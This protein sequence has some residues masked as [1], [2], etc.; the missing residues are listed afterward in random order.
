MER[1]FDLH[2]RFAAAPFPQQSACVPFNR[3]TSEL[4]LNDE[5]GP[6][7]SQ[8]PPASNPPARN[9]DDDN[10]AEASAI[11][12]P[13]ERE[14]PVHKANTNIFN[15]SKKTRT[16]RK[17]ASFMDKAFD[18]IAT[19]FF[20]LGFVSGL[21]AGVPF[22]AVGLVASAPFIGISKLFNLY[23]NKPVNTLTLKVTPET[24]DDIIKQLKALND[25]GRPVKTLRIEFSDFLRDELNIE[26]VLSVRDAILNFGRHIQSIEL[27]NCKIEKLGYTRFE[28]PKRW[29]LPK[30]H[31]QF[32]THKL[33][34]KY[35]V[36]SVVFAN[37]NA[38]DKETLTKYSETI[39]SATKW[40]EFGC[41]HNFEDHLQ[42]DV[43][44][45]YFAAKDSVYATFVASEVTKK[46][47][48]G[49]FSAKEVNKI[50]QVIK[51][52]QAQM[53]KIVALETKKAE[54]AA[55]K[56]EAERAHEGEGQGASEEATIS[57]LETV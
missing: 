51:K 46:L 14:I 39:I 5:V 25:S 54:Q 30:D 18:R 4:Y 13:F 27:V 26:D 50:K 56:L 21:A 17:I 53:A 24:Y 8:N 42:N 22:G 44:E 19:T 1:S 6:F 43:P 37:I 32:G 33:I 47:E 7:G 11:R 2:P 23:V 55:A 48:I 15:D 9:D 34:R 31:H 41:S 35:H 10:A 36:E 3:T 40:V 16:L 45:N 49:T 52:S 38:L 20:N 28:L 12:N 29:I 57:D